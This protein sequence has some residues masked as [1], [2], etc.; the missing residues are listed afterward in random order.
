MCV[1]DDQ[2]QKTKEKKGSALET[3]VQHTRECFLFLRWD[4]SPV[5]YTVVQQLCDDSGACWPRVSSSEGLLTVPSGRLPD[6][7]GA[8]P[9]DPAGAAPSGM[10]TPALQPWAR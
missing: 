6:G 5:G 10:C 7:T 9:G 4:Q 3:M 2:F 1:F 8:G